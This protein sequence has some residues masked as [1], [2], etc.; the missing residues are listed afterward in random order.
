MRKK[1]A[2]LNQFLDKVWPPETAA[3][4]SSDLRPW[5]LFF[6]ALISG[7][8]IGMFLREAPILGYDWYYLFQRNQAT[9]IYYPPWHYPPWTDILLWPLAK[10]P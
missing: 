7:L 10:L 9:N 4:K 2:Q 5:Q 6:V 8:L 1:M 3:Q